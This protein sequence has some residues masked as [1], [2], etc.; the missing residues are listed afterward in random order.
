MTGKVWLVGAGPGDP[1]LFTLR[2]LEVLSQAEVVVYDALVGLGVMNLIP[3]EAELINVGKRSANHTMEQEDINRTLLEKA[4]EGKRVVRL[5][6]GDP[7]LFGRGGEELELLTERGIPYEVVPGVTSAF[8]VPAYNGIPVTHR[9][10]CSSVHVVTGHRRKNAE[11]DIDFEALVRTGGTLIFLMGLAAMEDI[12]AGLIK[13][14]M[15]EDTPAA[16]LSSGTTAEQRRVVA[17]L[18]TLK[19][20]SDAAGIKSPATIVVGQVCRLSEQFAWQEK[21]PLSGLRIL[22]TRPRGLVS[23]TAAK[24]RRE[25][26]EVLELPAIRTEAREDEAVEK[27]IAKLEEQAYDWLVF[28]SPSG[29]DIFL[30]AFL[31]EHDIRRLGAVRIA[32]LGSGTGKAL[33][34]YGLRPDFVPTKFDGETLGREM[35]AQLAPGAKVLIARAAIGNAELVEN[36]R[37]VPDAVIDDVATYDTLP[38]TS[39]VID[40]R[41]LFEAGRI[42]LAMFTSAS[43]VRNFAGA[44]PGL[45]FTG[46]KAVC[47]GEKTEAAARSFGMQT[48]VSEK[49]TMDSLVEKVK[50]MVNQDGFGAKTQ[51]TENE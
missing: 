26:A 48:V 42:D 41:P 18:A 30:A 3:P 39:R 7:F 40:E 43:S 44:L 35:A 29:V 15:A 45:D 14:G 33:R 47:I 23:E 27:A 32:V 49:A 5:K 4:L 36:L 6:G 37:A 28:T 51:K 9:D 50:E 21:R 34:A 1:G 22:I 8:A 17:T 12:T 25:G 46:V 20:E 2:G 19:A 24:L 13:A 31:R 10:F 38:E 16:V 11:Y